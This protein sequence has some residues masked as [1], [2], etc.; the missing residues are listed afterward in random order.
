MTILQEVH[1]GSARRPGLIA[2]LAAWLRTA[3]LTG[4]TIAAYLASRLFYLAIAGTAIL[5]VDTLGAHT[6]L[7]ST[8]NWQGLPLTH[9]TLGSVMS[10]WDGEW[11]LRTAATWYF[12]H[13]I[14]A[15]GAYT[16]LGFMPMYPMAIWLVAHILPIGDVLAGIAVSMVA[17]GVATVLVGKLARDWWGDQAA[18]RAI[19][20]W[21]LFPGTIVFSMVYSEALTVSLIA[22][23]ML[24][25]ARRRWLW[26]GVLAGFA[27][28]VA[29]TDLAAVPM[30]AVAAL[31]EWRRCGWSLRDRA[32]RFGTRDSWRALLAPVLSVGGAVGFGI[33]LWIWTGSPFADYTA[34]HIE[35]SESTTP[36]AI[37]NVAIALGRQLFVSGAGGHGPGG[38]DLNNALAL[39]GTAFMLFALKLLWDHRA[40]V[41]LTTWV[42]TLVVCL[43]AVT[44]ANTPPNPRILIDAFP[45]VLAA[46]AALDG[47]AHR[48][49]MRAGLLATIVL[50]PITYVGMWLRP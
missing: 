24:L 43:L 11:Y 20:F 47:R 31:L 28:A 41:P 42:W 45:L 44:S 30:C 40:R 21:C 38:V 22:G 16:T 46:G 49:A 39:A 36:L 3:S 2:Y 17:G 4:Y 15:P 34:Q 19:R 35:W 13:V 14:R 5:V 12:H 27:T 25:L 29:P 48:R 18:R 32:R 9:S 8:F 33:Y 37:P 23:A 6:G 26:A 50:S 10:N 7:A 1:P